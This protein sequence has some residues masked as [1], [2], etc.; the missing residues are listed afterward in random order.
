MSSYFPF[1]DRRNMFAMPN[2]K[3]GFPRVERVIAMQSRR[4]SHVALMLS[5][6]YNLIVKVRSL[7]ILKNGS[8]GSRD[9]EAKFVK[10]LENTFWPL[11]S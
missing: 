11:I 7:N 10:R 8:L 3:L 5:L 2:R 9:L 6:V 1:R 4:P